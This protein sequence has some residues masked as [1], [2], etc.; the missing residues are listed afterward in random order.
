M[1]SAQAARAVDPIGSP[2]A[3]ITDFI[4]TSGPQLP[5]EATLAQLAE[6]SDR[7]GLRLTV[8]QFAPLLPAETLQAHV[9]RQLREHGEEACPGPVSEVNLSV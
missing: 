1:T 5:M 4:T 2:S 7:K 8:W 9:Q 3:P 6:I